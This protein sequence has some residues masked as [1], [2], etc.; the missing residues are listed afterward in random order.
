M[1]CRASAGAVVL[2][3]PRLIL[4]LFGLLPNKKPTETSG[5]KADLKR[6]TLFNEYFAQIGSKTSAVI[7]NRMTPNDEEL[8]A[9]IEP[10][11]KSF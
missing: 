1:I 5:P 8:L 11:E 9:N 6:A 7:L 10:T 3:S 2:M 4:V